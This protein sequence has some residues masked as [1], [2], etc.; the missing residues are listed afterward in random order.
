[1]TDCT[2]RNELLLWTP[3]LHCLS[4][5]ACFVCRCGARAIHPNYVNDDIAFRTEYSAGWLCLL[6][7]PQYKQHDACCTLCL[8]HT[9]SINGQNATDAFFS[10][11]VSDRKITVIYIKGNENKLTAYER[12]SDWAYKETCSHRVNFV[13]IWMTWFKAESGLFDVF[14]SSTAA[15]RWSKAYDNWREGKSLKLKW[16]LL[17]RLRISFEYSG[18]VWLHMIA[19]QRCSLN[20]ANQGNVYKS[21]H[22]Y[23]AHWIHI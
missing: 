23:I 21:S 22:E 17:R 18:N 19:M 15:V 13:I 14:Y 16:F 6:A 2:N 11:F 4:S 1:M 7:E 3:W 8:L 10:L 9:I 12:W 5:A 20:W